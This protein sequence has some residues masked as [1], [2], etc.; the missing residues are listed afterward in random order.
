MK[1]I[2]SFLLIYLT[3]TACFSE[4][5]RAKYLVKTKGITIG[6]LVW[7]I[8]ITKDFYETFINLK[9]NGFISSFYKFSGNYYASGANNKDVLIPIKYKQIWKTKKK[10]REV[11]IFFE[12]FKIKNLHIN[13]NESEVA[14]VDL[15]KLKNYKDPLTSFLNILINS[16][17]TNTIDGRRIY[18]LSPNKNK[19]SIKILIK[20]YKN[21]WA[22]HKRN[23]LEYLE[24][25]REEKKLLP[26]KIKIKFK[27]RI[28]SLIKI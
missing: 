14:R 5:Y 28:F 6:T 4:E 20:N 12:D 18:T 24:F 1:L 10:E 11:N 16:G 9:S 23:E 22:D 8:S 26:V 2:F 25:F 21:L 27:G 15:K 3:S 17:S 13:P 7:K 19:L